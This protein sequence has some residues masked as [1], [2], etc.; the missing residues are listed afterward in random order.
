MPATTL[1][2]GHCASPPSSVR[3]PRGGLRDGSSR[4]PRTARH[5]SSETSGSQLPCPTISPWYTDKPAIRGFSRM[6]RMLVRFHRVVPRRSC[7]G[8]VS[9]SMVHSRM[10][11]L[12]DPPP[13]SAAH[14]SAT[15]GPSTE[16]AVT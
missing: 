3:T 16:C 10:T 2:H 1:P 8:G 4:M 13:S 15:A 5:V 9:S 7:C 6:L 11:P 14:A 12:T